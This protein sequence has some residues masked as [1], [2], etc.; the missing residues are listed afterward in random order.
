[1]LSGL[2][3]IHPAIKATK[4]GHDSDRGDE[5]A[6]NPGFPVGRREGDNPEPNQDLAAEIDN[7]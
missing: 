2:L 7:R 6:A 1:L 3:P 5:T 4:S